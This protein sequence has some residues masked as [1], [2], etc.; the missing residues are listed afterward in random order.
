MQFY[1]VNIAFSVYKCP[2]SFVFSAP[3]LDNG[4]LIF[5]RHKLAHRR[6]EPD[7]RQQAG[8][9]LCLRPPPRLDHSTCP[10]NN[11]TLP[12]EKNCMLFIF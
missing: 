10:T 5:A 12:K 6:S 4:G 7:T 11:I 8:V 1:L 2:L 3:L 9:A